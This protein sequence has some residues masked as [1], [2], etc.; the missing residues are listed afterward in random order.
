MRSQTSIT[1]AMLWSI[2][3][4]PAPCSSRTDRTT[5]GE[6]GHLRLGQPRRRLVHEHEPRPRRER[7]RDA[8]APL[9]AVG[10]VRGRRVR[11]PRRGRATSSTPSARSF[12]SRGD[13]PTPSAATST[14]SRTESPRKAWLCWNVRV[15]PARPRRSGLQPRHVPAAELD[16]ALVGPVE[17]GEHVDERRLAGAVRPD[18]PHDLVVVDLE[19]DAGERLHALEGPRDG[20]G[21]EQCPRAAACPSVCVSTPAKTS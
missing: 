8:E 19:I 20:G 10:E 2:R 9:V 11:V 17:A 4:T 3:S 7:P 5:A 18:Q 6:G 14:F 13:A 12:A 16:R 1:S 15:R 21:P